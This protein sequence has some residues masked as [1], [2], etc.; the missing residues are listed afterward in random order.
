MAELR[1]PKKPILNRNWTVITSQHRLYNW[2][3]GLLG[4]ACLKFREEKLPSARQQKFAFIKSW[5]HFGTSSYKMPYYIYAY[6]ISYTKDTALLKNKA[7]GNN[8]STFVVNMNNH[9]YINTYTYTIYIY[10]HDEQKRFH[11]LSWHIASLIFKQ[12]R[13]TKQY[14]HICTIYCIG[15]ALSW[16]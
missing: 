3:W 13:E 10:I 4:P 12:D 9:T 2:S 11:Y 15:T 6:K 1:L 16:Q 8:N 14:S 7:I 5:S